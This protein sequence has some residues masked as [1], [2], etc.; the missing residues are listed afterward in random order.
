[1]KDHIYYK[2]PKL[3]NTEDN[4]YSYTFDNKQFIV[5]NSTGEQVI[6]FLPEDLYPDETQLKDSSI[7]IVNGSKRKQVQY[8]YHYHMQ[9]LIFFLL[10]L[11]KIKFDL[12]IYYMGEIGY[13]ETRIWYQ[14]SLEYLT[15][16]SK[17]Y[18][19][20]TMTLNNILKVAKPI[21]VP[22]A[23]AV[24]TIAVNHMCGHPIE[25]GADAVMDAGKKGIEAVKGFC[26]KNAAEEAK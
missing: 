7:C 13:L 10:V 20:A 25:K 19:G 3:D 4:T 17:T 22:V 6:I 23:A 1:M 5:I 11:S 2:M 18:G 21:I 12:Y 26:T 24:G 9:Q 8:L 15:R 14:N 16:T